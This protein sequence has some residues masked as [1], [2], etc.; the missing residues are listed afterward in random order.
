MFNVRAHIYISIL[1]PR[2][3]TLLLY[4]LEEV[5]LGLLIAGL[6]YL[7]PTSSKLMHY[8]C[9]PKPCFHPSQ[10][11][12]PRYIESTWPVT[13]QIIG[14]HKQA[15]YFEV[16]LMQVVLYVLFSNL[17]LVQIDLSYGD[18]QR[19]LLH[20]GT[21]DT[22]CIYSVNIFERKCRIQA[23]FFKTQKSHQTI[24]FC[25]KVTYLW[26]KS[27]NNRVKSHSIFCRINH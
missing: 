20:H 9:F 19:I 2:Y 11:Q 1:C 15:I 13:Y 18:H 6:N 27:I 24:Q 12:L 4:Y 16:S 21:I 8:L 7:L 25:T 26:I 10:Q 3:S 22:W 5:V 23:G 17:C 14:A